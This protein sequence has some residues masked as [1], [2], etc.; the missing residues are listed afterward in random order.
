MN[1][2][3]YQF[4]G[5]I[6]IPLTSVICIFVQSNARMSRMGKFHS[7]YL[8]YVEENYRYLQ[9]TFLPWYAIHNRIPTCTDILYKHLHI[10]KISIAFLMLI[11]PS[12]AHLSYGTSS[13]SL[14]SFLS[15]LYEYFHTRNANNMKN[16]KIASNAC[17]SEMRSVGLLA[18]MCGPRFVCMKSASNE[19][20]WLE[21]ERYQT[22]WYIV[23]QFKF[24]QSF[25]CI[26]KHLSPSH[27]RYMSAHKYQRF[28]IFS[29]HFIEMPSHV[30]KK[31]RARD[32]IFIAFSSGFC[33]QN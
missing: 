1:L 20:I 15:L 32:S 2:F 12:S 10:L 31:S 30:H 9:S 18:D 33:H 5:T 14:F 11:F 22:K 16:M 3:A 17:K 29:N 24:I 6:G 26:Q 25:Q 27:T 4:V 8:K 13:I 7:I 28:V 19:N 23:P 21:F